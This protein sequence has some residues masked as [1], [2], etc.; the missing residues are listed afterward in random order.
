MSKALYAMNRLIERDHTLEI[1]L[2][3]Y[4]PHILSGVSKIK[5]CSRDN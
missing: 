5:P 2:M 1:C 4:V 3:D